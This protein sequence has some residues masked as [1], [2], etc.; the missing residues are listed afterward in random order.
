MGVSPRRPFTGFGAKCFGD[1]LGPFWNPI[2]KLPQSRKV[3]HKRAGM[4]ANMHQIKC[5]REGALFATGNFQRA[6]KVEHK[7]AG[8]GPNMHQTNCERKGS[9]R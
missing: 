9:E 5:E 2:Q 8:M 3:E 7:R 1:S 4:G 6:E